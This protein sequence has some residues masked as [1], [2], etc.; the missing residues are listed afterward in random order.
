[1]PWELQATSRDSDGSMGSVEHVQS[2]LR[3]TVPEIRLFRDVSGLEKLREMESRGISVPAPI[4]DVWLQSKGAHEGI[5]EGDDWTIEFHLGE[6]EDSVIVVGI[7][8][9]GT[10]NPMAVID[11]LQSIPDWT[12]LDLNGKRP[13]FEAWESFGSWRDD[14]IGEIKEKE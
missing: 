9:R 8:V 7:D 5:V 11:R 13:T 6:D 2:Q 4:R 1:M 14:A 3:A 12:I 10:G